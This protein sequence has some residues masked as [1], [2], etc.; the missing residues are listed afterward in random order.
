MEAAISESLSVQSRRGNLLLGDEPRQQRYVLRTFLAILAYLSGVVVVE[1]ALY[2]HLVSRS[3][4]RMYE[5]AAIVAS[6]VS[7]VAVRSGWS[8]RFQDPAL[9]LL[10]MRF[11]SM[12][13]AWAYVMFD[14]IRGALLAIQMAVVVFGTF[15]L[16]RRELWRFSA[17][18]TLVMGGCMA[19]MHH[20]APERFPLAQEVVH[21]IVLL[22]LQPSAVVM[23]MQFGAMRTRLKQQRHSLQEAVDRIQELASRDALTGLYNRR[24]ATELMDHWLKTLDRVPRPCT[25]VLIDLDH[26]K[27]INDRF[28]HQVGDEVL[29]GFAQQAREVL[30]GSELIARWGGEEFLLLLP[31]TGVDGALVALERLR[32]GLMSRQVATAHADVKVNFSSGV[33]SLNPGGLP[34][35][36]LHRA[37]TALYQSKAR[38][39]GRDTIDA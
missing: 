17:F 30:R 25:V 19:G 14:Q 8:Q 16:P 18:V 13:A 33:T 9:T 31:E 3:H 23:E 35:Q 6:V 5:V 12:Y 34:E 7:Y 10:Q 4:V 24:H 11:A 28:G 27:Q 36:V 1:V 32:A 20:L 15:N 21:F 38:G 22:S 29:K 26:F 39:R 2:F 37:D